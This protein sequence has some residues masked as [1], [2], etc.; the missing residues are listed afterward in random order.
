MTRIRGSAWNPDLPMRQQ[1]RWNEHAAFMNGLAA[2]G[3]VVLGGP[4]GD[5]ERVLLVI[6]AGGIDA[7]R[8]RLDADP[9]SAS[10][11]L[12]IARIQPWTV[13]LDSRDRAR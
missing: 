10:R 8:A 6:E 13:L 11:L 5:G 3:F 7:V 1:S 4:L 12:E 2:E 9:W